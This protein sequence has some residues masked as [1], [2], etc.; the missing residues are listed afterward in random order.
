MA[1][2]PPAPFPPPS[3]GLGMDR[4]VLPLQ[5]CPSSPPPVQQKGGNPERQP[6]YGGKG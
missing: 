4:G 1:S 5:P 3:G 6:C 2:P